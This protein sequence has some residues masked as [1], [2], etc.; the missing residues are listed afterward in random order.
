M[1]KYLHTIAKVLFSLILILPVVGVTG[2]LGEPT[3]ELYNTDQAY[4]FIQMLADV[5]YIS[6]MMAVVHVLA[7]IALWTRREPLAA[8]LE[9]PI[10]LNV[11]AFHL[12]IDG[13]LL[14]GGAI[15]ANLM[16]VFNMYLL[17]IHRGVITSLSAQK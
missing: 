2:L 11:V 9:L 1:K 10:T 4:G 15:L 6:Y 13:G 14:T 5:Q 7:L 12:V 16:L 8:L 3:R 17:F